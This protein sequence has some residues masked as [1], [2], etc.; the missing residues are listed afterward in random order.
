VRRRF[1]PSRLDPI[2]LSFLVAAVATF[3]LIGDLAGQQAYDA[4]GYDYQAR[5]FFGLYENADRDAS[6]NTGDQTQLQMGWSEGLNLVYPELSQPDAWVTNF[7]KGTYVGQDGKTYRWSYT[8]R[9][10]YTGSGSP[11]LGFFTKDLETYVD[12]ARKGATPRYRPL[13]L[14]VPGP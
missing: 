9:L 3:V 8:V 4:Y 1:G 12:A 11:V 6:N 5:R 14:P 7:Q 2:R 13:L 10:R